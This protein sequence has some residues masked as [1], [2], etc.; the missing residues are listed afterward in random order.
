GFSGT[1]PLLN[2]KMESLLQRILPGDELR[3]RIPNAVRVMPRILPNMDGP[4][5]QRLRK[6]FVRAFSK[7]IIDDVRPYVRE[8]IDLVLEH[9]AV[10]REIEF[11]ESVARQVPGAVILRLL[12]MPESYVERLK[13]WTDG[14]TQAL[15]SFDPPPERLDVLEA[16]IKDMI[17]TFTPLIEER[18]KEPRS[19][20]L[21]AL[22]HASD[23]GVFLNHDE[24]I[25]ALNLLVVAGHDTTS[26]SM[27]LSI[28]ALA[29]RPDAWEYI[30]NHP[31]RSTSAAIEL[32]RYVAMSTAQPRIV[33]RNFDWR[34][35]PM[36]ENDVVMLF[37]AGGNRDPRV[38]SDPEKLDFSRPNDQALTF[39]PGA[40]HC[41]GHMLAKLQMGEFLAAVTQRFE[42]VEVL[43][44]PQ[45]V[46]NL[47]FRAVNGLNVR[48]HPRRSA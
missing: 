31:E 19:D 39:A 41:I 14:T 4:E 3:R 34:G 29:K 30:R 45:W 36:R 13:W 28:R 47:I 46:A 27:T 20:F 22:V 18:R 9:A 37:I 26:N 7:K 8:R 42:R 11:N 35:H 2:G 17:E 21:S 23:S 1:L 24:I 25:A 44:E 15:V 5:H 48:F 38:F 16:V 33:G 6:L 12:G 43:E 40:H 10:Q 32:M